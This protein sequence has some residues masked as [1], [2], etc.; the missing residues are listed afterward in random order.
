[1][2]KIILLL[3]IISSFQAL[4]A[5]R[6][7]HRFNNV[8]MPDAL[9]TLERMTHRYTINFIYNDL[10]DFRVTTNIERQTVPEALRQIIGFYPITATMVND[11]LIS[12]ECYQKAQTR[13]KGRIIDAEGQ[14]IEFANVTLLTPKDSAFLPEA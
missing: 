1:M 4:S 13:Y 10:E 14:P 11:S 12:V 9:S 8:T 6:I 7:S 2:K 5:Q 3:L